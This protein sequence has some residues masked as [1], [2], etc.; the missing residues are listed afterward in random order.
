M[1]MRLTKEETEL[2][3]KI[4]DRALLVALQRPKLFSKV[5]MVMDLTACHLNGTPLD[6]QGLL[7]ASAFDFVH[8]VFGIRRHLDR[9]TGKLQCNFV[10]RYAR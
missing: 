9:E 5:E 2:I 8:D 4:A 1:N 7:D 6:L 3:S 10:P